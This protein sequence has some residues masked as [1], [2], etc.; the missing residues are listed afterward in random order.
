M[1]QLLTLQRASHAS[2]V[3]LASL[4]VVNA[5][6]L[7]GVLFLGWHLAT[8]VATYWLE[9]GVIGLFAI[10]RIATAKRST[11]DMAG[12]IPGVAGATVS[13]IG[14]LERLFLVPFFCVHYGMFWFVH[15]M[16]V[17]FALPSMFALFGGGDA[18]APVGP[19]VDVVLAMSVPLLLSHGASFVFNW[20]GA[21][22]YRSSTPAAEM[23]AP[24]VRVVILHLT[25]I[26]GAFAVAILGAPIWAMVVMVGLKTGVD[27]ASHLAERNRAGLRMVLTSAP[28]VAGQPGQPGVPPLV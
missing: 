6:P 28:G 20:L 15:G 12:P 26:F 17:W 11:L 23:A 22:E 25:I 16:F 24:Y 4:L 2:P 18:F 7:V 27:V 13:T 1:Q 19:N 5:I 14:G 9:N 3:A 21:G 8:I 10:G